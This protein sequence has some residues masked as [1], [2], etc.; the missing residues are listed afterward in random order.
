MEK[1]SNNILTVEIAEH[2]AELQSIRK[3]N[4]EYLWQ[5]DARFWG[6]RSP[7]LFPN[8]GRVWNDKYRY[9]DPN[10]AIWGI[11]V[12]YGYAM[13]LGKNKRWGVEFTIGLG[14]MDV[15]YDVY[16]GVHNGKY[17]R[18]ETVNYWGPTRLGVNFSYRIDYKK[19][20]NTDKS[21]GE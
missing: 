8:V 10:H 4:K 13:P 3:N 21:I 17:L 18:T 6:R 12:S 7:V 9:Q 1:I 14:Y 20:K 15:T 2:G 11:G 19:N 16:E 5:G